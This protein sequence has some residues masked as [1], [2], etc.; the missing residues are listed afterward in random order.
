[1]D[2]NKLGGW[3][4][5]NCMKF[6][7]GR[8]QI[9]HLEWDNPGYRGRLGNERPESNTTERDLSILYDSV[10]VINSVKKLL[11]YNIPS[12][13]GTI[14]SSTRVRDIQMLGKKWCLLSEVLLQA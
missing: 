10:E 5:T 12:V 11:G 3:A 13:N 7:K 8:C 2:P 4:I 1:M 9:L 14:F 6:S